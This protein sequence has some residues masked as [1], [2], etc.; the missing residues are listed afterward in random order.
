MTDQD[1]DAAR[2][3]RME[4]GPEHWWQAALT[5]TALGVALM[6]GW[7][8]AEL[9]FRWVGRPPAPVAFFVAAAVG[10][11]IAAGCASVVARALGRGNR[12]PF[13]Q[14]I[15]DALDRISHGDFSVRIPAGQR[16]PLSELVDSVNTM[17]DQLGDLERQRQEFISNVSHEIGSPLTSIGGFARLARDPGIDEATRTHYLDIITAETARLSALSDNL[18]RLST[19][20]GEDVH[21]HP[22]PFRLDEQ[23]RTVILT[24]EPQWAA[25]NLDVSLD[26]PELEVDADEDLLHQVWVNLINNAIKFTPDGGQVQVTLVRDGDHARCRVT[27][28]GIGIAPAD[29]LRIFERF[30]RADAARPAGGNGL[31]LALV[32][33]VVDL[34]DGHLDVTSTPGQGTTFTVDIPL[35]PR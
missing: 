29:L 28:T 16:H 12:V 18:L 32:R 22:H 25:K 2:R 35:A 4:G 17:A 34:V 13:G 24:A 6:A 33:R 23:L 8:V 27:D 3:P 14:E 31:G 11:A 5:L 10:V 30:F 7:A 20:D 1:D 19:L 15:M 26:A 21:T 9:G